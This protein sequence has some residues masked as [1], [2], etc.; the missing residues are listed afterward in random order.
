MMLFMSQLPPDQTGQVIPFGTRRPWM[1]LP[2]R[3]PSPVPD[4]G[5]YEQPKGEDDYRHRMI[6]NAFAFAATV[7]L[8]VAGIWIADTLAEMRRNQ[9]CVLTGRRGC[10]PVQAPILPRY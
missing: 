6:V 1:R 7:V 3:P 8:I 4:L 2:A 10:T 9:D 5:Q